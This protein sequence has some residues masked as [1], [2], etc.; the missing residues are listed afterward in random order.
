MSPC[1]LPSYARGLILPAPETASLGFWI[2]NRCLATS[3]TALPP[4]WILNPIR[5]L[6][7]FS[8]QS[9][10]LRIVQVVEAD[11]MHTSNESTC[12]VVGWRGREGGRKDKLISTSLFPFP[13]TRTVRRDN[14]H[15]GGSREGG[16]TLL[17]P[18][19]LLIFGGV[20]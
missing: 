18:S 5:L 9:A 4:L 17:F 20:Q 3:L 1:R 15:T 10:E 11:V 2:C 19:H 8:S 16:I 13:H 6:K 12:G 7:S 14:N